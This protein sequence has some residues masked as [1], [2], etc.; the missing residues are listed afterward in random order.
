MFTAKEVDVNW[1]FAHLVITE[2]VGPFSPKVKPATS[3]AL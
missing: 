2:Y 3:C 1:K